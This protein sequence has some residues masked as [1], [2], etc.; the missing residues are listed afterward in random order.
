MIR[1]KRIYDSAGSDDGHRVLVDRLWPRGVSKSR[2]ALDE[3]CREIAPGDA[4]RKW[5]HADRTQR[6]EPFCDRYRAELAQ[7]GDTLDRLAQLAE[8]PGLTLL[9][10]ARDIEHSHASVLKAL[11]EGRLAG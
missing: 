11:L 2:A 1:L 7:A 10:A 6:W 4:L 9:T 5:V 3:W 8:A